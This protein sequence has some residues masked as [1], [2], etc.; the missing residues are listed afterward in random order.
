MK[1]LGIQ[2]EIKNKGFTLVEALVA[3]SILMIAI[4]SP[5]MLTQKSLSSATLSKDQMVATFLA[6]DT[7]EA[8][9]NIRD[10]IAVRGTDTDWLSSD[11]LLKN[12][13]CDT[14]DNCNFNSPNLLF[15][16]IDTTSPVW[17]DGGSITKGMIDSP[18]IK[19]SYT[20]PDADGNR[21]FLKYD[22]NSGN[23]P[24]ALCSS[25]PINVG[26]SADSKFSRYINIQR[27]PAGGNL[28][29]AVVSVRVSWDSPSGPQK[30]D[31]QDFLYNY[32]E[33]L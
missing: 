4:A 8:V 10:Q 1:N 25:N 22:Y 24:L 30:V 27:N 29:E 12:C 19:I 17:S 11:I 32:S 18:K 7:I 21:S 2:K 14:D 15:C 23:P 33:K 16:T 9:R 20:N 6:Q 5:M 3:I 13:I 31:I 28:N 26:C